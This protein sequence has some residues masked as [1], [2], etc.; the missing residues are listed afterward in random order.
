[1]RRSWQLAEV[2]QGGQTKLRDAV[3]AH[4]EVSFVTMYKGQPPFGRIEVEL[5]R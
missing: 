3:A 4:T 5:R 1:M 2:L